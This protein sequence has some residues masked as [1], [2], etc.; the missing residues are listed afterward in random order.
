MA[1]AVQTLLD[2]SHHWCGHYYGLPGRWDLEADA[3]SPNAMWGTCGC[4]K[5][6]EDVMRAAPKLYER[7]ETHDWHYFDVAFV[8]ALRHV[9]GM[10]GMTS[11]KTFHV[12]TPP[13]AHA[14]HY[15]P[16]VFH[17]RVQASSFGS[18]QKVQVG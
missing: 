15:R 11:E 7:W 5:V 2:C 14:I 18:A 8:A 17:G 13:V 6:S 16:E 9:F 3:D 4:C 1:G 12:H 10:E